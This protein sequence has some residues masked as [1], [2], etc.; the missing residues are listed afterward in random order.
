[1]EIDRSLRVR[2]VKRYGWAH[3]FALENRPVGARGEPGG[4][5]G[6]R[7]AATPPDVPFIVHLGEGVDAAAAGELSRIDA[8]GCL[9]ENTVIVHGVALTSDDWARVAA[10]RASLVWCP[11]S[12][13]FL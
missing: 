1:R 3:S 8:L 12:N 6:K 7:Y 4:T 2:V 11:A 13:I 9:R 5:V 10:A